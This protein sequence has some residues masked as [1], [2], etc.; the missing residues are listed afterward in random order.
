MKI[1]S[2]MLT[3]FGF[4]ILGGMS[5]SF[6]MEIPSKPYHISPTTE[7]QEII[8]EDGTTAV[9]IITYELSFFGTKKIY[10]AASYQPK[11]S[12][13][14]VTRLRKQR[15]AYQRTRLFNTT[16]K[17][18]VSIGCTVGAAYLWMY[19]PEKIIAFKNTLLMPGM[20]KIFDCVK[21]LYTKKTA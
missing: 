16:L 10:K 20:V 17:W 18:S 3:F 14:Y 21:N 7:V 13:S 15:N 5:Q 12:E 8:N 4:I 6:G 9:K 11:V 2:K 1:N 19:P